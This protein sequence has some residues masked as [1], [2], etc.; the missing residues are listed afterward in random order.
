MKAKNH[1]NTLYVSIFILEDE[2]VITT[3][4][5]TTENPTTFDEGNGDNMNGWMDAW[6]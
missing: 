4:G 2:D 5:G 1:Y 3:S 6:E